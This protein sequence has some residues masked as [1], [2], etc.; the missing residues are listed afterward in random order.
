MISICI[1]LWMSS[2]GEKTKHSIMQI[3]KVDIFTLQTGTNEPALIFNPNSQA[4]CPIVVLW[5]TGHVLYAK[6]WFCKNVLSNFGAIFEKKNMSFNL[7]ATIFGSLR[8]LL[9]K[10]FYQNSSENWYPKESLFCFV[11]LICKNKK[12][13]VIITFRL[14]SNYL[15]FP[16]EAQ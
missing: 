2:L 7:I 14:Q 1:L 15:G 3:L 13:S 9:Y 16:W 5:L 4:H 12:I 8:V 11:K 6:I 10:M